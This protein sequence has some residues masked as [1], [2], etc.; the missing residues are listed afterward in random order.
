MEINAR[1][2]APLKASANPS[3]LLKFVTCVSIPFSA[4]F[5]SDSSL[6]PQKIKFSTGSSV[7]KTSAAN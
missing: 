6:Y 2:S 1:A 3:G 7:N 4:Y 5:F